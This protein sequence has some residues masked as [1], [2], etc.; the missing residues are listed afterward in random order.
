MIP[1]QTP[2]LRYAVDVIVTVAHQKHIVIVLAALKA[3]STSTNRS[4]QRSRP[5]GVVLSQNFDEAVCN[6][7]TV[8]SIIHTIPIAN[9]HT[10][11]CTSFVLPQTI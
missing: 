9:T 6:S 8:T 2:N 4:S 7:I 1:D 10:N 3:L 5:I 11:D